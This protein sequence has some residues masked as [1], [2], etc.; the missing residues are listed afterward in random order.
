MIFALN[1]SNII[2]DLGERFTRII[3]ENEAQTEGISDDAG[4][5]LTNT[6]IPDVN[7]IEQICS[8]FISLTCP[9]WSRKNSIGEKTFYQCM[10]KVF[11]LKKKK[12]ILGDPGAGSR[13]V[14]K[15]TGM[16][17]FKHLLRL[18][19]RP[20]WLPLGPRGWKKRKTSN[21]SFNIHLLS[22]A[23]LSNERPML[24][25]SIR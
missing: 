23:F 2:F 6:K 9:I 17:V 8:S 3:I 18:F 25:W 21:F 4:M 5:S 24:I 20:D 7:L 15:G 13:V 11:L 12:S 10:G 1:F 14:L 19:S 16:K 22:V